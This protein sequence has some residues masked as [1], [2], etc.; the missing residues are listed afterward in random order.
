M[1][2]HVR[3]EYTLKPEIEI[4]AYKAEVGQFVA[5]IRADHAGHVYTVYQHE[6]NA[7]RFTHLGSFDADLVPAMQKQPFFQ[8]FT[9]YL[10]EAAIGGPD[11]Q[12]V[13]PVVS[14]S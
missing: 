3:I 4:D 5:G 1:R 9:A 8:K 12:R 2:R 6:E 7:R 14:T 10:R 11:V 13:G